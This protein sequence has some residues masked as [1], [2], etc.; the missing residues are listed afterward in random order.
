MEHSPVFNWIGHQDWNRMYNLFIDSISKILVEIDC[1]KLE[2][3]KL[4]TQRAFW[5]SGWLL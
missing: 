3:A 2:E 1:I 4:I 5:T